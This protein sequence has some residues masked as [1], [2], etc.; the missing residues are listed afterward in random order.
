MSFARYLTI[1]AIICLCFTFGM[2]QAPVTAQTANRAEEDRSQVE[3]KFDSVKNET[4][5]G[6]SLLYILDIESEKFL[7]SAQANYATQ[8]PKQSPKVVAFIISSLKTGDYKYPDGMWM[9]I[10]ADGKRLPPIPLANPA[11]RTS[12][13]IYYET[14]ISLMKYDVFM[15]L[16]AAKEAEIQFH[17]SSFALK[18][19]H[20]AKL[21]ELAKLLHL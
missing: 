1:C 6:F 16:A 21:R 7:M 8:A 18:E 15:Q 5:V 19:K 9:N 10:T 2:A 20:L 3:T 12:E 17:H 4:T 11:K 13:G 14:L